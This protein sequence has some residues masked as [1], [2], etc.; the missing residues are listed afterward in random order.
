MSISHSGSLGNSR[1]F[2]KQAIFSRTLLNY[3]FAFLLRSALTKS[4]RKSSLLTSSPRS[5]NSLCSLCCNRA[6]DLPICAY[7]LIA[8]PIKKQHLSVSKSKVHSGK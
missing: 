6:D 1:I 7:Y 2:S 3:S 4:S 8:E 5:K